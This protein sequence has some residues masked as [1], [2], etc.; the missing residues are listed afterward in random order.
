MADGDTLPTGLIEFDSSILEF[1]V[2]SLDQALAGKYI[3]RVEA[4]SDDRR[5]SGQT[6]RVDFL[7]EVNRKIS[8]TAPIL[9]QFDSKTVTFTFNK[10]STSNDISPF[11]IELGSVI[12][13]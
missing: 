1:A 3:I 12:D 11:I 13:P 4:R 8:N 5:L 2:S 9:E 6:V 7:L 10:N